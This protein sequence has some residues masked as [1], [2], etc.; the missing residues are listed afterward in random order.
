MKRRRPETRVL[1]ENSPLGDPVDVGHPPEDDPRRRRPHVGPAGGACARA[2]APAVTERRRVTPTAG[3]DEKSAIRGVR[4]Q[5]LP[6]RC[7]N[8]TWSPARHE[9]TRATPRVGPREPFVHTRARTQLTHVQHTRSRIG[10]THLHTHT[11]TRAY[12]SKSTNTLAR[13]KEVTKSS[14]VTSSKLKPGEIIFMLC[15][16][17]RIFIRY[18]KR[19]LSLSITVA[20]IT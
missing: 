15:F 7:S 17:V 20:T 4:P 13:L 19:R 14:T 9:H 1:G 5:W 2:K 16:C 18:R 8:G 11:H 3:R 6:T 10:P 12:T